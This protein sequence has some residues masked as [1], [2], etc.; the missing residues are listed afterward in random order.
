MET[1]KLFGRY[2][3]TVAAL[4]GAAVAFATAVVTSPSGPV[5][6]SEWLAGAVLLGT[7]AGVYGVRN[8]PAY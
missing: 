3:K 1:V 6:A 4:V 8:E 5:T 7:A 2:N